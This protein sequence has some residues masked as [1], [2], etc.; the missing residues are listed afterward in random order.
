MFYYD[1]E[2]AVVTGSFDDSFIDDLRETYPD[3]FNNIIKND[4]MTNS[5]KLCFESKKGFITFIDEL[6]KYDENFAKE[7][8]NDNY[9]VLTKSTMDLIVA[10]NSSNNDTERLINITSAHIGASLRGMLDKFDQNAYPFND[11]ISDDDSEI[12]AS[13]IK[14]YLK[15]KNINFDS[16]PLCDSWKISIT[17]DDTQLDYLNSQDEV[18]YGVFYSEDDKEHLV[19]HRFAKNNDSVYLNGE[20]VVIDSSFDDPKGEYAIYNLTQGLTIKPHFNSPMRKPEI[21]KTDSNERLHVFNEVSKASSVALKLTD[22]INN[23][24]VFEKSSK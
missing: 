24:K 8:D 4:D 1:N 14:K 16:D 6:K 20:L 15:S 12:N 23:K 18:S 7:S 3:Y 22:S 21:H 9:D 5:P 19:D 10:T 13:K 2:K 17:D 11:I